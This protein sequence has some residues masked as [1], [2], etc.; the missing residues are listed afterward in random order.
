M[1]Q[2]SLIIVAL[3]LLALAYTVQASNPDWGEGYPPPCDGRVC[4]P[5][6]EES[7]KVSPYPP[8]APSK[9]WRL[10]DLTAKEWELLKPFDRWML[11]NR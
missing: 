5:S 2:L 9:P 10:F 8:P 1:K 6:G 4:P 7:D 11:R 3:A